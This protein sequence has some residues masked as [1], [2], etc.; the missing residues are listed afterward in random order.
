MNFEL[1]AKRFLQDLLGSRRTKT[2]LSRS[3][4]PEQD[5]KKY[6]RK[7]FEIICSKTTSDFFLG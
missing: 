7:T 6:P 3:G 1:Q 2:L 4:F 5:I